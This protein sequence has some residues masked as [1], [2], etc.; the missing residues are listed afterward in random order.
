MEAYRK[1]IGAETRLA[2]GVRPIEGVYFLAEA[3]K[4][5]ILDL[6]LKGIKDKKRLASGL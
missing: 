1:I 6:F 3:G 4:D 2:S 5:S